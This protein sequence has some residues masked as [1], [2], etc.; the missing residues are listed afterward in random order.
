MSAHEGAECR[1][2]AQHKLSEYHF[3]IHGFDV[4]T[5]AWS[6]STNS[7]S[8]LGLSFNAEKMWALGWRYIG[9]VVN[10]A[11]PADAEALA[12]A[13][14]DANDMAKERDHYA[15]TAEKYYARIAELEAAL[16]FYADRDNWRSQTVTV[17]NPTLGDF[18][19]PLVMASPIIGDGGAMARNTLNRATTPAEGDGHHSGHGRPLTDEEAA[20]LLRSQL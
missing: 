1:P 5:W 9:P 3:L 6:N 17:T 19:T 10:Q 15:A 20:D 14:Q 18:S 13:R 16:R 12:E 7:W 4:K 2:D 11:T 8:K